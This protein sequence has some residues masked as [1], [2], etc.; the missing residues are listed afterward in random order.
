MRGR[1]KDSEPTQTN[2]S[3]DTERQDTE[4]LTSVVRCCFGRAQ[5]RLSSAPL[6]C[7][8]KLLSDTETVHKNTCMHV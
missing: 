8:S 5:P 1:D 2:R 7:F 4:L 6:P 3:R